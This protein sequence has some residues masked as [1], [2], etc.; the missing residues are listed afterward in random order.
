MVFSTVAVGD[1]YSVCPLVH[2]GEAATA[3]LMISLSTI[4]NKKKTA[5]STP[6]HVMTC[7]EF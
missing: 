6:T 3:S 2:Y 5:K 7:N 1:N 4:A